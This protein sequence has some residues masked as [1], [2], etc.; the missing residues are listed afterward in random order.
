MLFR[1]YWIA[2]LA[3][4]TSNLLGLNIQHIFTSV[5][6]GLSGYDKIGTDLGWSKLTG[7]VLAGGGLLGAVVIAN[8]GIAASL[9]LLIPA[10][11]GVLLAA[12]VALVIFAAR[13]ALITLCILIAPLA[14]V[15]Y[16]LPSTNKYFDK[17]KDLFLTMLLMFPI[18]SFVFGAAQLA[19]YAIIVNAGDSPI[20]IIIGLTV[21]V[22]PIAIT[23]FLIRS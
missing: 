1:S 8:G 16:I 20:Q 11:V 14:F 18:I 3:V 10:L 22:A 6:E 4:D 17:W 15:A 19:G 9:T 12:F 23:P 13:Q 7:V 21:Q 5:R 2:S